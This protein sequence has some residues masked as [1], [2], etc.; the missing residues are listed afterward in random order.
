MHGGERDRT[1]KVQAIF[2]KPLDKMSFSLWATA[3]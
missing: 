1:S 2:I 3:S